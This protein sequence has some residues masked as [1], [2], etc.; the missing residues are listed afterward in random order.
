[1][2]K[3]DDRYPRM[4]DGRIGAEFLPDA[5]SGA[6]DPNSV[7]ISGVNTPGVNIG[8]I[9][10]GN[11]NGHQ[12]W[13]EDG[14]HTASATNVRLFWDGGFWALLKTDDTY[15]ANVPDAGSWTP[16]GLTGWNVFEGSGEPVVSDA[17]VAASHIGQLYRNTTANVWYRATSIDPPVWELDAPVSVAALQSIPA[18][19]MKAY[20]AS[21]G[22][23]LNA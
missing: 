12:S 16:S 14:S 5:L 1:M 15:F 22:V 8:L 6:G 18:A 23:L 21:L 17:L 13:S 11:Y 3:L 19:D 7:E 10:A 4:T 2:K 20:L 9:P